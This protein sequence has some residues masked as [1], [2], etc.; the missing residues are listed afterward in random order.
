MGGYLSRNRAWVHIAFYDEYCNRHI[1]YSAG[2]AIIYMIPLY[3][4]GV[5]VNRVKEHCAAA[6]Y[7]NWSHNEKRN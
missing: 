6:Y 4:Y 2:L 3:W 1:G 5:Y 7:Y